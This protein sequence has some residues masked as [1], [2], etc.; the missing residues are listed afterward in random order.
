LNDRLVLAERLRRLRA[1]AGALTTD[2]VLLAYLAWCVDFL[3]VHVTSGSG[4]EGWLTASDALLVRRPWLLVLA[5]LLAS[6]WE[7]TGE[8]LGWLGWRVECRAGEGPA[9]SARLAWRALVQGGV[10]AVPAGLVLAAVAGEEHRAGVLLVLAAA[11]FL[12]LGA[13][14][15]LDPRGRGLVDRLAGTETVPARGHRLG[16]PRPWWRRTSAWTVLLLLALTFGVGA[17]LTEFDPAAL[18]TGAGNTRN[19]WARLLQPDWSI[20]GRVVERMVETVFLALMASALALPFA[21][22]LGFLGARNVTAK[23]LSGRAVYTTAR[24]LMT[25]VRSIEPIIWAIVFVLWVGVGPF[26]GMLALFGHSAAALGKLY[27]EAV[28]SIDAG[29]VEAI[30]ATGANGLQTLRYGVVPQVVMPFLAFTVYR[31]DINVRMAT[32]LGF[33]GGGGIGGLLVDSQQLGA[34]S[35]VGT[36][37]LFITLVVW[38]MDL[39]SAKARERLR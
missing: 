16:V 10:L 12:V 2:A 4:R 35:K 21:F 29:P 28:E 13:S 25:V 14:A 19:L 30:R 39:A 36:I 15:L 8:S 38:L 6:L 17:V 5:P 23:G 26:A 32:I 9:S 3:H 24:V 18:A 34:W 31:W 7:A 1:R 11:L 27:S 33:V 20:A 22:V 37:I